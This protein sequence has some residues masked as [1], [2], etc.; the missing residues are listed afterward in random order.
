LALVAVAL[1]I[2][3]AWTYYAALAAIISR[4]LYVPIYIIGIQKIRSIIF[5]PFLL[6]VPVMVIGIIIGLY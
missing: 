1:D 6:A 5:A 4:V 2:S 3:N